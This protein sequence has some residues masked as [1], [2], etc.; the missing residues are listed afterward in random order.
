MV[1]GTWRKGSDSLSTVYDLRDLIWTEKRRDPLDSWSQH[2]IIWEE[3][4]AVAVGSLTENLHHRFRLY[5]IGVLEKY[6]K[7]GI[8]DFLIKIMLNEVWEEGGLSAEVTVDEEYKGFFM[9][10]GFLETGR[11]PEGIR[12]PRIL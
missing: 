6:R 3:E 9:K 10:Q 2:L 12:M 8:G 5:D 7:Q 11:D 4:T 1:K